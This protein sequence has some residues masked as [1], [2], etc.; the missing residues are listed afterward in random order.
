MFCGDFF[1]LP[2][3]IQ[4]GKIHLHTHTTNNNINN[5]S[6]RR[7]CFQ[8][9]LWPQL[10]QESFD[11]KE[12]YRQRHDTSSSS[13]SIEQSI[14]NRF[15]SVLNAIRIGEFS[16]D[17]RD[18]MN[19]CVGVTFDCNDGILPTLIFTHTK[20]VDT[21]NQTKLRELPG[22]TQT[23]IAIDAGEDVYIRMLQS[24]C[25]AKAC[26]ELKVGA[27]VM[28]VKTTAA[29][30]GLVNGSRGTVIGFQS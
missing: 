8:S 5:N 30:N 19:K 22:I 18:F 11:L 16:H 17:A 13:S 29:L 20:E 21:L 24:H 3:V 9:D 1:Q 23:F 25:R 2:P 4:Q 6:T 12:V 14:A 10:I 27:Q 15:I 26:L 7:F 28:L